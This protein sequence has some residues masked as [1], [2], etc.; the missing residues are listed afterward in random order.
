MKHLQASEL[1][2]FLEL[3]ELRQADLQQLEETGRAAASTVKLDQSSVGR[4]SRMDAMQ[5]QAMSQETNRRRELELQRIT[6]AL[7]R[8]AAGD[9]GDCLSC[10]EPIARGRLEIE[11]TAT[12]CI[13]CA[14]KNETP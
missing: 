8:L 14:S 12:Q 4:L 1:L 13:A 5:A 3:L 11:P 9:Y 7:Q 10:G 2:H 6:A